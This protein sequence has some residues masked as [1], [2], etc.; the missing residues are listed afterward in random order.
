[1]WLPLIQVLGEAFVWLYNKVIRPVAN[2]IIL[3]GNHLYNAIASIINF[4]VGIINA[5]LG[6]LGVSLSK[7]STVAPTQGQFG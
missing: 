3:I 5:A 2:F 7:V 6:W 1:M 4:V